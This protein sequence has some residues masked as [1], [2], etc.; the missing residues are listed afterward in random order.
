MAENLNDKIKSTQKEI[1]AADEK[2][3]ESLKKIEEAEKR[4]VAIQADK[5]LPNKKKLIEAQKQLIE[6]EKQSISNSEKTV[7]QENKRLTRLQRHKAIQKD[8]IKEFDSFAKSYKNLEPHIKKQ[9]ELDKTKGQVYTSLNAEIAKERAKAKNSEGESLQRANK[10]L[11]I[12]QSISAEQVQAAEE[13]DRAEMELRGKKEIDFKIREIKLNHAL[14]KA[15]K[16]RAI[17]SIRYSEELQ[18]RAEA[19]NE[20]QEKQGEIFHAVPEELQESVKGAASFGRTLAAA[21]MAAGP[22]LLIVAG[23]AAAVHAFVELDEAGSDYRKNTGLTVKQTEHLDHQVHDIAM[24]YRS[25]GVAAKEVYAVSEQLGNVFSNVAHFSTETLGALSAIVARTGTTAENAAKVQSVFESIGGVSSET[26][27]SMQ[28]QV[29]SLAQQAGAAPKEVLDDIADSAEIT[30]KYFKGD[31]NLL[32]QQAIQA[33]RLGTTL[34]GLAKTAEKLLDFEGGIEEELVASTFVGGQFN[35]SR[36]RALAMEGKLA[37]AQEETLSQIQRSG[38]FRKQDYFTQKQLAAAAGMEVGEITKQLNMQERLAHLGEEEKKLAMQAVEAGLDVTDLTDEQLKNKTA[39]FAEN[40]RITGQLDEM[41]NQFAAITETVGGAL[42]PII[43]AL[44]PVLKYALWP[45]TKAA[46]GVAW[47]AEGI[48]QAKAPAI[49]LAAVLAG[50][51]YNSIKTAVAG[52][53][54]S[55][56]QIPFGLGLALAGALTVGL[57]S[58]LSKA[59][60]EVKAGDVMS[61]ADGKTRISTKEGGLLSLSSNDDVV[62]APNAIS[63]LDNASKL[64]AMSAIPVMGNMAGAAAIN[65]LVDEMKKMRQEFSSK[66]NDVYMDGSKVTSNLKR[67]G[68]K[69]NR[70]NFALA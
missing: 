20:I 51:A 22:L 57:F 7:E 68:D 15:Q 4:I 36:A 28:M 44:A 60:S 23:L 67:V 52:I 25:M 1:D 30:S 65:I 69:S 39:E 6:L 63:A 9:L 62:A 11:E 45:I 42:M 35:L 3:L 53:W 48:A 40:Q 27:A 16:E 21:G 66:S 31:I 55:L 24:E 8:S 19:L 33:N 56:G 10:R 18:H 13:A 2:R 41:K 32:K 43:S 26:A 58:S 49:A 5:A 12:L 54:S 46:E 17:A 61:P 14:T 50:M 59:D 64:G 29:A 70:N 37:E 34:D 47:L 38:D